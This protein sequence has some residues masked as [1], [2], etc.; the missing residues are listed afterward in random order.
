MQ[1]KDI[2]KFQLAMSIEE[3]QP[4]S[5]Q[6]TKKYTFL[7]IKFGPTNAPS[8][9]SATMKNFKYEWDMLFIETLRKIG[10]LI[11][12]QGTVTEIDEVFI[13]DLKN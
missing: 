2:I 3:N 7:V 5:N 8:F 4:Y 9:Y 6:T 13:G 1:D 12:E 11:N 10:T